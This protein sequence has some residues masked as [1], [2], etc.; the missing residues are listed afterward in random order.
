MGKQLKIVENLKGTHTITIHPEPAKELGVEYW[1]TGFMRFGIKS[2]LVT[3]VIETTIPRNEIRI[4][5]DLLV[6]LGLQTKC[7]NEFIVIENE[8]IVGPF[9]GILASKT[10]KRLNEMVSKLSTYIRNYEKIRGSIVAFSLEGINKDNLTVTGYMYNPQN[11]T[12][13]KG[14]Y[15][16]PGSIFKHIQ[17]SNKLLE[18]FHSV[19]SGKIFNSIPFNKW[20]M[21][22]WLSQFPKVTTNLPFTEL[23]EK[24]LQILDVLKQ[25]KSIIIKPLNY[26]FGK[27]IVEV[28]KQNEHQYRVRYRRK[29]KN[30][31]IS[32]NNTK[33]LHH[34]LGRKFKKN[35]FI[36]QEKLDLEL[37]EGRVIDFRVML[38]KD[39]TGKWTTSGII[40]KK[41]KPGSIVIN[42][43]NRS[44][45]VWGET[46]LKKSLKLSRSKAKEY[47]KR[48]EEVAI[49]AAECIDQCGTIIGKLGA[50]VAVDKS[51]KI[52][53]IELNNRQ[54]D[55]LMAS[56]AGKKDISYE[57]R[58]KNM[59]FAKYL[60]GF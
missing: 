9:I 58:L 3:F 29:G 21:Y 13:V 11:N 51:G 12:W 42:T 54:P 8:L 47:V 53:I 50:D 35:R 30:H 39:G 33:E 10:D 4:T 31:S 48:L 25:Y 55:D 57:V 52:W 18:H 22:Q 2:V 38:D 27:G 41:G 36:I 6:K 16:Y 40:G 59:L 26:S 15:P 23:Y 7:L 19:L 44:Q 34:F 56:Y 17:I 5:P 46:L 60:S 1:N 45:I 20:E 14:S 24:P 43:L 37:E 28:T 49:M 32:M